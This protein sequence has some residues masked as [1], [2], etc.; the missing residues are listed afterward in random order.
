[1]DITMEQ[2]KDKIKKLLALSEDNPSDA[3]GY[4][5]FQKAQELMARYKLEKSDVTDNEKQN[6]IKRKTTIRYGSR[7]SDHYIN[8]LA[9][10]IAQNFCCIHYLSTPRG[11]Q[12]HYICFMGMKDDVDIAGEVLYAANTYIIKGYDR[13]YKSVCK[14]YNLDY[15]PAK[16]FNPIKTGYVDGY[17]DGLRAALDSQKKKNQEWGLVLVVPQE[18][19]DFLADLDKVDFGMGGN[20]KID[21]SY[22]REGYE[23][24]SNFQRHKRLEEIKKMEQ[25]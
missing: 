16:Y 7:S 1:M 8:D 12:S 17:L 21:R 6:C 10:I 3:E 23:D 18:A 9:A 22:Y 13:V 20:N 19:T 5:A 15:L 11:S 2:V 25:G 4:V 14:E 24:G